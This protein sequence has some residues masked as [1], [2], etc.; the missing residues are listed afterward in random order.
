MKILIITPIWGRSDITEIWAY[1]LQGV[2]TENIS[3]LGI[4]SEEDPHF[5]RNCDILVSHGW[6]YCKFANKPLGN[7]LNAGIEYALTLDWDYMMNLGSDDLIHPA[8]L[9]LYFPFFE[10]KKQFFGLNKVFFYEK[11]T[12]KLAISK[13]YVWGAG[14]CIER[15]I[16][17]RLKNRGE[18]LYDGYEK[19][20][21]CNSIDRIGNLLGIK[22][23]QIETNDFPYI[24]DIKTNDSLNHFVMLQRFYEIVDTNILTTY[25][26]KII[27]DLL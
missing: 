9:Q 8:I 13:P 6:Y 17:E 27:T 10:Q 23:E 18:F 5:E 3:V 14:R 21:D 7:K 22:Y 2:I 11:N 16:I 15:N 4:V 20:L 1:N 19:G 12:K 25:Y 24:V 26:P